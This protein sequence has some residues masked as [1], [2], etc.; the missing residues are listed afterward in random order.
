M[1]LFKNLTSAYSSHFISLLSSNFELVGFYAV[2]TCFPVHRI[3]GIPRGS[4][5]ALQVISK[6]YKM[7][8]FT[9][10]EYCKQV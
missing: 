8:S 4:H 2:H 5:T 3:A 7:S 9:P 1:E 10:A 6:D